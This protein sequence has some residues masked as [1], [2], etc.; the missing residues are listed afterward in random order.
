VEDFINWIGVV[1]SGR[2]KRYSSPL[3]ES[4]EKLEISGSDISSLNAVCLRSMGVDDMGECTALASRI[5]GL[6][7]ATDPPEPPQEIICPLTLAV[8]IQPVTTPYGHTYERKAILQHLAVK[9]ED[10]QTR[11]PLFPS[12]LHP[13]LAIRNMAE[14]WLKKHPQLY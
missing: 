12:Q 6:Q 9:Y 7:D 3:K 5:A 1:S 2:F 13:S 8:F 10:P 4:L 14:E 11:Q